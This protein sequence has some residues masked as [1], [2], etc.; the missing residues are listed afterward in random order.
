MVGRWELKI[1]VAIK[2]VMNILNGEAGSRM[3]MATHAPNLYVC[4]PGAFLC[5]G[6]Y[7]HRL[8]LTQSNIFIDAEMANVP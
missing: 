3:P 8:T 2:L 1:Q 4:I 5:H 6:F 7:I